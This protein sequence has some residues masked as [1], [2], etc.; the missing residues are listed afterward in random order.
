M[1]KSIIFL[2]LVNETYQ[3]MFP[4]LSYKMN[5]QVLEAIFQLLVNEF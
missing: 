1:E 3:M 5:E 4:E 2:I